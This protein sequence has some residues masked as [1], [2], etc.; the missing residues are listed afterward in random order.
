MLILYKLMYFF[1]WEDEKDLKVP[2]TDDSKSAQ[3][4]IDKGKFRYA[5]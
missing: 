2:D 1:F 4:I 5:M 3:K